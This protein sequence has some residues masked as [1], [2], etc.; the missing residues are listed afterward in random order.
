MHNCISNPKVLIEES[1]FTQ[2]KS[3]RWTIFCGYEAE[4]ESM[5][6]T[7]LAPAAFAASLWYLRLLKHWSY[8]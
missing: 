4:I 7:P 1:I 2:N 5:L 6:G 3:H 8:W